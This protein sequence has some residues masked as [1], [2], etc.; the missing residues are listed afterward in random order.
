MLEHIFT[1]FLSILLLL[2]YF[3][4]FHQDKILKL[5]SSIHLHKTNKT[6]IA[7]YMEDFKIH[8]ESRMSGNILAQIIPWLF[9]LGLAY[10]L[11]NQYFI[12]GSVLTGSM[13]P[14]LMRGDLVLMQ[15]FALKVN[16]GDIIMFPM[17]GYYEPVT[18]RVIKITKEGEIV[19][20]GDA[21]PDIDG[22]FPAN[23]VAGKAI[24][25]NGRPILL[26]GWGSAI[27]PEQFGDVRLVT[28]STVDIVGA[29]VFE[30]FRA[31]QPLFIFFGTIFYFFL[32]IESRMGSKRSSGNNRKSRKESK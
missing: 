17:F 26:R 21:N 18:H 24:T 6:R 8:K 13:E 28:E 29:K 31:L 4:I 12:F 5:F 15:T 16:V 9:V 23:I 25:I 14:E 20:K 2:I 19:T 7:P 10:V 3:I 27:R 32:L 22:V 11:S 1:V 30:Q